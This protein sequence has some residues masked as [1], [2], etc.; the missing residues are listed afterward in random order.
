M[1]LVLNSEC[2]SIKYCSLP[3][4]VQFPLGTPF[5]NLAFRPFAGNIVRSYRQWSPERDQAVGPVTFPHF[6]WKIVN[7][8]QKLKKKKK[9][10]VSWVPVDTWPRFQNER[11]TV[12]TLS[13][14]CSCVQPCYHTIFDFNAFRVNCGISPPHAL[15]LQWAYRPL[16]FG[17]VLFMWSTFYT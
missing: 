14:I 12:F 15:T 4:R 16:E 8:R 5:I 11:L 6:I 2:F 10:H 13:R 9:K 17:M 7:Y 1:F 3:P